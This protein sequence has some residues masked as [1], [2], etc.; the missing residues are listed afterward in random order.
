MTQTNVITAKEVA[1]LAKESTFATLPTMKPLV[2][3]ADSHEGDQTR[4]AIEDMDSSPLLLDEQLRVD[5]VF[6]GTAKFKAKLKPF[7]TQITT[8]A[9]V[10]QPALFD[11]IEC[12]LGGMQVGAGSA[13]STGTTSQV[14]VTSDTGFA[15][16][17][18]V[19][20]SG[21]GD[22]QLAVVETKPGSNVVTFWPNVGTAV[23]S[24]TL[25]NSYHGYVTDS[26][27]K[28]FSYQ[29][30]YP[31][32]SSEQ[33]EYRGCIGKLSAEF[34]PN[35]L[36]MLSADVTAAAGQQGALGLST[37]VQSNP[38][39]T[40]GHAV[41]DAILYVQTAATTTR[42]NYCVESFSVEYDPALE[43]TP[44]LTGTENKD[45]VVRTKG[46]GVTKLMLTVKA[47]NAEMTAW[48][49]RTV[50]RVLFGVPRG[51]G[52]TKR[53]VYVYMPKAVLVRAPKQKKE[54][55]RLLYEL[56][57]HAQIDNTAAA[58]SVAGTQLAIGAL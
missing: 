49:A 34:S 25:V 54:G 4:T 48:S 18:V 51:S 41:K 46:R 19:G 17:Q 52:T 11:L 10:T 45:G 9:P 39:A 7:G 57:F 32:Y 22:V 29:H 26:D 35:G 30:A 50:R 13:I 44:C 6:E 38:L 15:I 28:T 43:F 36:V 14:T 2:I 31:D 56:E 16:G 21:S 47:D 24:G 1:F 53:W 20:I 37:S 55:G 58:N 27:V 3:E 23:T 5:G 40:G 33:Q 12:V 42:V 8:T